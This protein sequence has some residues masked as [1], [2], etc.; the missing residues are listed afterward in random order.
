MQGH[1]DAAS[2]IFHKINFLR[3]RLFGCGGQVASDSLIERILDDLQLL[4]IDVEHLTAAA[5]GFN[6]LNRTDLRALQVLRSREGMT[7]GQLARALHVTSGATTRIIDGLVEDGHVMREADRRDRRRVQ[8]RLTPEA[9]RLVD[10]T[11]D[12]LLAEL[13]GLL[14]DYDDEELATVARFLAD[15]RRLVAAHVRRLGPSGGH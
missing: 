4:G 10:S 5:A 9:A 13:R 6:R 12:P 7:A 2:N 8:V 1:L 3:T 15:V 11:F 14:L